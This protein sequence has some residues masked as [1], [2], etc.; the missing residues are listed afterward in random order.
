MPQ[1]S[2]QS[3]PQVGLR[4]HLLYLTLRAPYPPGEWEPCISSRALGTLAAP[5]AQNVLPLPIRSDLC[6]KGHPLYQLLHQSFPKPHHPHCIPFSGN[7]LATSAFS[8]RAGAQSNLPLEQFIPLLEPLP[9]LALH[10]T[11]AQIMEEL[12]WVELGGT[13]LDSPGLTWLDP[14]AMFL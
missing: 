8:G 3:P 2:T 6:I 9:C 14:R 13:E 7:L 1:P 4:E 12:K 5:S 10:T 11:D